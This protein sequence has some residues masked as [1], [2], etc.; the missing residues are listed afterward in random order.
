MGSEMCI[1]DSGHPVSAV[2][3]LPETAVAPTGQGDLD[4]S[5]VEGRSSLTAG[6]FSEVG[7]AP[8]A[9]SPRL[10]FAQGGIG[11]VSSE[12]DWT[13]PA[14]H[15]FLRRLNLAETT[16][17]LNHHM[18]LFDFNKRDLFTREMAYF[19]ADRSAGNCCAINNLARNAFLQAHV[20]GTEQVTMGHVLVAG[21]PEQREKRASFFSRHKRA[22][23]MTAAFVVSSVLVGGVLAG[24]FHLL[25]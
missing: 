8:E 11:G 12:Q 19:I 2:I 15:Y 21:M 5:G 18:L 13:R 22:V 3:F 9:A 6:S 24:L 16:E 17:Y 4:D 14:A 1:R 20:E 25:A 23:S 7:D 10:G